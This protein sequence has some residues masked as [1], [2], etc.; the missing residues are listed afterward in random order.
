M[1]ARRAVPLAALALLLAAL[2]AAGGVFLSRRGG[3]TSPGGSGVPFHL[4]RPAAAY[5]DT[6]IC[7]V[8]KL[9]GSEAGV[10]GQD[11]GTTNVVDGRSY[12]TFGDT[13]LQGG[14]VLPNN[15]GFSTDTNPDDCIDI[16]RKADA[17]GTAAPL[18]QKLDDEVTVW[19]AA[20][21][22]SVQPGSVHFLFESV[23][24]ADSK[25]GRYNFRRIGLGKFDPG[26]MNGTRVIANLIDAG[27]FPGHAFSL[28][29]ATDMLVSE[30]YVYIY[31]AVDWNARVGRV[32]VASIEDK[33]AYRYWNGS[34]W[35]ADVAQSI[36]ILQTAG[37]QQAF[38][39]DYNPYLK[40]WTAMYSTNT[41]TA[42]AIAYADAPAGPFTDETLLLDCK[43][44]FRNPTLAWAKRRRL[45]PAVALSYL[46]YHATQ[47]PEFD[48]NGRQALYI[49]YG[50]TASYTLWLHKIVLAVPFVQWD[51][52][53]GRTSYARG[54]NEVA[55]AA[56]QGVAF[57]APTEPDA[58]LAPVHDWLDP[59]SRVHRYEVDPPGGAYTD[60]GVA[61]YAATSPQP[62][63]E[64]V[65]RWQSTTD[66]NRV[67]YSTFD[68]EQAGYT[69]GSVGF[70]AATLEGQTP[71]D[72]EHGYV[73]WVHEQG[74]Q[75]FGCCNQT[76]NP[77]RQ[78]QEP[79]Q[80]FTLSVDPN[81]NGYEGV[82]CSPVCGTGGKVVWSGPVT[83][84][85]NQKGGKLTLTPKGQK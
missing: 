20:G 21:Q 78:T 77:T 33:A 53:A 80:S 25:T 23:A 50:N 48:K 58:S 82:V 37:G 7:S 68:L 5:A 36:D 75:D 71:V 61:F 4:E 31:F 74:A 67:V 57:Y 83:F 69:R 19:P 56:R 14:G 65:T 27:A 73:Y 81:P 38:N 11:G 22:V 39:V 59:T 52:V 55:A 42:V 26:S 28:T 15:V 47:H 34:D 45:F 79:S 35:A 24:N 6:Q 10:S 40:K 41:L 85:P 13:I 18:L 16:T 62:G 9:G 32:P 60:N 46:C 49:T 64:P 84:S 1:H 70:Y 29:P 44:I 43:A 66:E 2:A 30:G 17:S 51:D 72:T 63:L 3:G 54:G 76:N 12:W 8:L